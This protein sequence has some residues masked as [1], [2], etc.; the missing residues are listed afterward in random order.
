M[1]FRGNLILD[2]RRSMVLVNSFPGK[3]E[4]AEFY[5]NFN[6]NN[7]L[8]K[9]YGTVKFYN[10]VIT[11]ENFNVFYQTKD[12]EAYLTFFNNNY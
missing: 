11:R 3:K 9:E 4:A 12:L 7:T 1:N 2:A 5:Q 10:F 6:S 8:F